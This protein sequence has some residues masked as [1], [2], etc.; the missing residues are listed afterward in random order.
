MSF[1]QTVDL[2]QQLTNCGC[3]GG[4][5]D[6]TLNTA[7]ARMSEYFQKM[8]GKAS[9]AVESGKSY[10]KNT[11]LPKFEELKKQVK[12]SGFR[13]KI[14]LSFKKWKLKAGE[15]RDKA[16]GE[17]LTRWEDIRGDVEEIKTKAVVRYN[18]LVSTGVFADAKGR[19][20]G[21]GR[22]VP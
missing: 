4:R 15:Y 20:K 22:Q 9:S 11:L 2:L 1:M 6:G 17:I 18:D 5:G 19:V 16:T 12:T 8:K 7:S 10:T 13:V 21:K 14:T 3:G